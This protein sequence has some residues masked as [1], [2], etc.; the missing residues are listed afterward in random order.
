MTWEGQFVVQVA[1]EIGLA[2]ATLIVGVLHMA[3]RTAARNQEKELARQAECV[4]HIEETARQD[5]QNLEAWKLLYTES[6]AQLAGELNLLRGILHGT[7]E[8]S[9]ADIRADQRSLL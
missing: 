2:M 5:A 7:I 9:L 3:A 1:V 6:K 4:R 8:S